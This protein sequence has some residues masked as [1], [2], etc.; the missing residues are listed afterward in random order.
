MMERTIEE[1]CRYLIAQGE[2]DECKAEIE[3]A[4][5]RS[6][7]SPIP[8]NLLGIVYEKQYEK[9]KALKHYRASYCLDPTYLPARRNMER[10]GTGDVS[11][12]FAYTE[13]DCR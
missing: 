7:D 5:K 4:M 2:Y 6:P 1:K 11:I 8:H 3:V 13:K 12:A 9:D 10:L